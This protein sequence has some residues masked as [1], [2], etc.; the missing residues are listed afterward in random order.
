MYEVLETSEYTR[1]YEHLRDRQA[2]MRIAA[3]IR[4]VSSGC[5][6]DFKPV[7]DGVYELR[8]RYGPGYRVYFAL[9]GGTLVIL[10]A[11]GDKSTQRRDIRRAVGVARR[12]GGGT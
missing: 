3:R 6:G 7:G 10:L 8:I 12:I 11:G 5:L 2:R 4:Q 1:W 9:Q